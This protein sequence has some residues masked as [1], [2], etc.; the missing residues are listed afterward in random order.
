MRHGDG[1]RA[2][3]LMA[4]GGTQTFGFSDFWLPEP[5]ENASLLEKS[6]R[7]GTWFC[8]RRSPASASSSAERACSEGSVLS[9]NR[10]CDHGNCPHTY[11]PSWIGIFHTMIRAGHSQ[12][13]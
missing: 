9:D 4:A 10:G 1:P 5:R 6:L 7:V 13:L 12:S 3:A 2:D 8:G 11:L